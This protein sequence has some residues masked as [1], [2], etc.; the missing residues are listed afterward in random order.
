[1]LRWQ[2]HCQIYIDGDD[3]VKKTVE[4]IFEKLFQTYP[5]LEACKTDI[6]KAFYLIYDCYVKGGKVLICG[7]GGSASDSEHIVGELMKGFIHKRPL[8]Q[9]DNEIIKAVFPDEWEY[10]AEHLQGALPAISLVSQ[11]SLNSAF[12]NDVAADMAFAQQVYGYAKPGD[13]VIGITTSGNSKNVVNAIKV[14]K[15]FQMKSVGMT[16]AG[17]GVL[18]ILCD[19]TIEV[20]STVTYEIQEYHLPVYHTICAMLEAELFNS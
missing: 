4:E 10:L 11:T 5:K 7:N 17:G 12:I 18:K 3:V 8:K 20:P 14:A 13:V 2:W 16:G 6:K 19:A 1:M 9:A 15:A